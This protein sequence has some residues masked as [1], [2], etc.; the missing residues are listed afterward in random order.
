MFDENDR[1]TDRPIGKYQS[2]FLTSLQVAGQNSKDIEILYGLI[3]GGGGGGSGSP[4]FIGS[5]APDPS[6]T[7]IWLSTENTSNFVIKYFTGEGGWV[8]VGGS[9]GGS[10]GGIGSFTFNMANDDDS[11]VH[12][13]GGLAGSA[14]PDGSF[15]IF[16]NGTLV[17]VS[18][19]SGYSFVDPS[20][21]T[22]GF[23]S[24]TL[25]ESANASD[26]FTVLYLIGGSGGSG[27][28]GGDV[29][30]TAQTTLRIL[31]K[32]WTI[33]TGDGG[34]NIL[35]VDDSEIDPD[36]DATLETVVWYI[37]KNGETQD[38]G[39][40]PYIE[41]GS[42]NL[43]LLESVTVDGD[44]YDLQIL[45]AI[46]TLNLS[47][48]GGGGDYVPFSMFDDLTNTLN[49]SIDDFDGRIT[50]LES[51]G[52]GGDGPEINLGWTNVRDYGALGNDS[53][54]DTVS[55][56][57][58]IAD[59][60]AWHHGAVYFP[61]GVYKITDK[62]TLPEMYGLRLFGDSC[63]G[64]IIKQYTDNTPI[65]R[66]NVG[67]SQLWRIHDLGF[68]WNNPQDATNT[69]SAAIY[70]DERTHE[71][72][73]FFNFAIEYCDF[74]NGYYALLLNPESDVPI[75][76]VTFRNSKV[77]G[78]SGGAVKLLPDPAV[79][80]PIMK[81]E[82][83]YIHC[84]GMVEPAFTLGYCD[85]VLFDSV[86]FNQGTQVRQIYITTCYNVTMINCRSEY[87]TI[88]M[89]GVN[90][91]FWMFENC[92][93]NIIGVSFTNFTLNNG[94]T[95]FMIDT[96]DSGSLTVN[97]FINDSIT[98]NSGAEA[99]ATK[100]NNYISAQQLRVNSPAQR[101]HASYR[102]KFDMDNG[103]AF[104]FGTAAPTANANF[105]GQGFIKTTSTRAAYIAVNIGT[106]ASDWLQIG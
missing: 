16:K 17:P 53:R 29:S 97:S 68:T 30:G 61:K 51:G 95:L 74:N 99:Y 44:V 87:V 59:A 5:D 33:G 85:T 94:G 55:I 38:T 47:G 58:A 92:A 34:S 4:I 42:V 66:V 52:G 64:S 6:V 106:G 12:L 84:Q 75:W 13:G 20:D 54:D 72:D 19:I 69:A 76:G 18:G 60:I 37:K 35:S 31:H 32:S 48:G 23:D 103:G 56:Q 71:E 9:G 21:P 102:P 36:L 101:F 10:G 28:S 26:I 89:D 14:S 40:Y 88:D 100:S 98:L 50:V 27:G 25:D 45:Y 90:R 96:G 11:T 86:E 62:I 43:Q 2:E 105:I 8:T 104:I 80:Q 81:F 1:F 7:K 77:M 15:I 63:G 83:L 24:I 46:T 73:T 78:M 65:F 57:E 22:L 70:F 79:G 3:N 91:F 49:A 93:T 67:L 82:D 39:Y 41:D